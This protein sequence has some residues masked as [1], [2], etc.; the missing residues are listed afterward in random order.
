MSSMILLPLAAV[1]A[2]SLVAYG[3]VT[4]GLAPAITMAALVS[5]LL[6]FVFLIRVTMM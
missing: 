4:I 5:M 2:I 6:V 1:T 3:A